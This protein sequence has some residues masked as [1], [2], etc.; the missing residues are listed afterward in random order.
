MLVKS[1]EMTAKSI[2]DTPTVSNSVQIMTKNNCDLTN[3]TSLNNQQDMMSGSSE[4]QYQKLVEIEQTN[5]AQLRKIIENNVEICKRVKQ[6][7]EATKTEL[8]GLRTMLGSFEK[9][10]LEG[11]YEKLEKMEKNNTTQFRRIIE[12]NKQTEK[13]IKE[14]GEA[15]TIEVQG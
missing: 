7:E 5:A 9:K 11:V 15:T 6:Q 4:G 14:L 3:K 8:Q 13:R 12:N 10:T 2:Q 1:N